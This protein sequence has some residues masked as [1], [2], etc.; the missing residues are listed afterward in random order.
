MQIIAQLKEELVGRT[1]LSVI[2]GPR[3]SS[4]EHPRSA[5]IG[6]CVCVCFL[7]VHG[8]LVIAMSIWI[9]FQYFPRNVT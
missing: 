7:C 1:W 6:S 9:W 3:R 2:R 5:F 8:H 4:P